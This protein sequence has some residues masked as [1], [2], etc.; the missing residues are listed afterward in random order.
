MYYNHNIN[1]KAQEATLPNLETSPY[2]VYITLK[3]IV[4]K[5]HMQ[6]KRYKKISIC[7][8]YDFTWKTQANQLINYHK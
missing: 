7:I 5:E 2:V 4:G 1:E 6:R 3:G 8:C